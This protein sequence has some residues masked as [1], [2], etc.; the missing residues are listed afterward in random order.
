MG[1]L[2]IFLQWNMDLQIYNNVAKVM[3]MTIKHIVSKVWEKQ[4]H[5][6]NFVTLWSVQELHSRALVLYAVV[7]AL[8]I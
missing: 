5:I 1:S 4:T 7:G 3:Y 8:L 2:G 6:Q